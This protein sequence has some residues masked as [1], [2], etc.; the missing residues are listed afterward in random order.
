[1]SSDPSVEGNFNGRI[2]LLRIFASFVNPSDRNEISISVSMNGTIVSGMMTGMKRYYETIQKVL[3][4]TVQGDSA[5]D[6]ELA[7]EGL[8][9][10]FDQIKQPP[11]TEKQEEGVEYDHIFM[12]N[13]KIYN[14]ALVFPTIGTT[15]WVGRIDSVDGFCLGMMHALEP[16]PT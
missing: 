16:E 6:T 5:K 9:M 3:N 11:S 10:M 4:D 7:R 14:G 1:M 8:K 13:V 15:Y 12:R 2:R